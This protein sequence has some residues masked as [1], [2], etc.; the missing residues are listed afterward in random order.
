MQ[1]NIPSN[2]QANSEQVRAAPDKCNTKCYMEAITFNLSN[3]DNHLWNGMIT[4]LS[5]NFARVSATQ[6]KFWCKLCE[7]KRHKVMPTM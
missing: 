4:D 6:T 3:K 7:A 1:T 5:A 2:L